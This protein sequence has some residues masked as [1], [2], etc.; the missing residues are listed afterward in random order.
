MNT[1][2][3]IERLRVSQKKYYD[4]NKEKCS[5][6]RLRRT[7]VKDFGKEFVDKLYEKY[8]NEMPPIQKTIKICRAYKL[9]SDSGFNFEMG[10]EQ[11][12]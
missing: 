7:Y 6:I 10:I 12:L 2:T 5:Q 1:L 9:L 4:N 3:P 11:F 8:N